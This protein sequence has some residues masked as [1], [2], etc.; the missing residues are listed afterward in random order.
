MISA[1]ID[2]GSRTAKAV[3]LSDGQVVSSAICDQILK[4]REIASIVMEKALQGTTLSLKDIHYIVTTGYGRFVVPF[5]HEV[6]SEVSCH[7]RGIHWYFPTVRTILDIG[8]QDSKAI[9]CN[10]R[11]RITNFMLNDKCAGGTGRFLEI[12]GEILGVSLEEMGELHFNATEKISF[13]TICVIFAKSEVLNM[14]KEGVK[15]SDMIAGLHDSIATVA[16]SLLKRISLIK[17]LAMSGGVAKNPGVVA[18]IRE[19]TGL[20]PLLPPDPQLI[21]ALGAALF[22][23][24]KVQPKGR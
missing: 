17:D 23:Q 22:A 12:I 19:K 7:A 21:G 11:G 20:E 14:L 8:G 18:K 2:I 24:D 4:S 10:E 5:A 6:I 13:S 16:Y 1:G 15:K 3:I 9:N